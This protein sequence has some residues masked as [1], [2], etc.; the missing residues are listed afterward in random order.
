MKVALR[1]LFIVVFIGVTIISLIPNPENAPAGGTMTRWLA[2][3]FLGAEQHA[4]K[5][6]HFLA[7]GALGFLGAASRVRVPRIDALGPAAL[8]LWGVVMELGQGLIA[9]RDTEGLDALANSLGAGVGWAG[10][11]VALFAAS[12]FL[13]A[14]KA[15]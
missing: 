4:D 6:G 15:A 2:L 5:V 11:V 10:G 1:G 8:A 7:Y 9:A 3:L 13:G 14:E 12:R